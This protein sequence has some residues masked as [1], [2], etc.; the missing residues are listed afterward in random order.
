[1]KK[2][3]NEWKKCLHCG[4]LNKDISNTKIGKELNDYMTHK[5]VKINKKDIDKILSD[6]VKEIFEEEIEEEFDK[7]FVEM[8]LYLCRDNHNR[9]PLY[10]TKTSDI[11]DIKSFYRQK[12]EALLTKQ[13]QEILE[14]IDKVSEQYQGG[15]NGRR[16]FIQLKDIIKNL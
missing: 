7:C 3:K 12:I 10:D 6:K 8:N 14:E 11:D 16:L 2:T 4:A 9:P 13:K 5:I 15:G 1:M